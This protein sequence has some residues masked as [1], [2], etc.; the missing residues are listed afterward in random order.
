MDQEIKVGSRKIKIT[1][2]DK[3]LFPKAK[4][5]KIDFVNYY[6]RIAKIMIK[7]VKNRPVTMRR[8][9]NG[10]TKDMFYQKDAGKYMADW[11]SLQPVK[12]STGGTIEY[13]LAANEA[14]LVYLANLVCVPHVW[15][16][17]APKLNYPDRMIF[18]FDPGKGVGFAMVRW[19]AKEVKKVLEKIGLK[20]FVMTTGSRGVHVTVPIKRL[21]DF[22]QV[23]DFSQDVAKY[24]VKKYPKKL[25][26]EMRKAKRG[27]RIFLDTLRNAWGATAVAPYAVRAKEGAPIATPITW[28]EL[29]S[30]TSTK[31]TIKNIFQRISRKGDVWKNIE[32]SSCALKTARKK[33]DDLIADQD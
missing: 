5:T 22:D 21:Y 14:T 28:T 3:I 13:I 26:L 11:I 15:L 27:K 25:T 8:F 6:H 30:V 9:P 24:L 32:K 16:S 23:R 33:L 29:S 4:I 2:P 10:V 17:R 12:K 20:P 19:G 18:D 7:H 1:N 31:Y